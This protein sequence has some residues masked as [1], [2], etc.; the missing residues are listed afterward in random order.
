MRRTYP[1]VVPA[2]DLRADLIPRQNGDFP[3]E[4]EV[5]TW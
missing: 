3:D 5:C 4:V 1:L 2:D